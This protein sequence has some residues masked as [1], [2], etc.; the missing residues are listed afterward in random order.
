MSGDSYDAVVVGAGPAGSLAALALA[1]GGARVALVDKAR[2]PRDKACGD[3]VGPR[4]VAQLTRLGIRPPGVVEVGDMVVVGPTGGR[5]LLPAVAGRTYPGRAWAVSRCELDAHLREAA[6]EAGAIP[7]EG[8]VSG[9]EPGSSV[10]GPG[11]GAPPAGKGVAGG[12]D[13]AGGVRLDGGRL[14]EAGAVIGADGAASTVADTAGLVTP[15]QV[16]WGF[17]IRAYLDEPVELPVIALWDRSPGRGFPGYGWIFPGPGGRANVGLGLGTGPDRRAGSAAARH[18]DDFVAHL[19]RHGI[20][21]PGASVPKRGRLGG[22][23]KMGMVGTVPARGNVLVVGDAAGLVN[24]LQGEGIAQALDTGWAAAQAV[25]AGPAQAGAAYRAHLRRH[26]LGFQAATASVHA[27]LLSRPRAISALGRT[28]TAPGVG[29]MIGGAWG[30]Y[31]NDLL[32]GSL[33]GTAS[34]LGAA[35]DGAARAATAL[36]R[37]RRW[38]LRALAEE[39]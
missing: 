4:G 13:V 21:R 9:V 31:W 15:S 26:Y 6:L 24:P 16:L 29:R 28:L 14:L 19:G 20:T 5:A 37:T 18:L 32:A 23:L 38:L 27:A 2:F 30:L 22:W 11:S 36:G 12:R 39:S 35:A 1:R 8:R 34:R 10:A 25:L 3:L 7:V 33:P 17:A